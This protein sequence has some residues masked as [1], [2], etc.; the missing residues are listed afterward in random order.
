MTLE[1]HMTWSTDGFL[2]GAG[3]VLVTLGCA[4]QP[5]YGY[6]GAFDDL[7]QSLGKSLNDAAKRNVD[8]ALGNTPSG[9][10]AQVQTSSSAGTGP[11]QPQAPNAIQPVRGNGPGASSE[12][13]G[14]ASAGCA[15]RRL[16]SPQKS[17]VV[18]NGSMVMDIV[19]DCDSELTV[20]TYQ[21]KVSKDVCVASWVHP[22]AV[23]RAMPVA[24]LCST[25]MPLPKSAPYGVPCAC[26][27]GTNIELTAMPLAN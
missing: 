9:G 11:A 3:A 13:T 6:A 18:W 20:M 17:F 21:G 10:P 16:S 26:P 24:R 27:D 2:F 15:K 23:K 4:L 14:Q 19:N 25:A 5:S 12:A 22:H 7:K 1:S 8:A